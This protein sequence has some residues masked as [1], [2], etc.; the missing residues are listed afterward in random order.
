MILL[1]FTFLFFVSSQSLNLKDDIQYT[2]PDDDPS[3][4]I[5][6]GT[7]ILTSTIAKAAQNKAKIIIEEGITEI[8]DDA[9]YRRIWPETEK[10]SATMKNILWS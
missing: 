10:L 2:I 7:G 4:I 1:L 6:R 8:A 9:F 5:F 3:S